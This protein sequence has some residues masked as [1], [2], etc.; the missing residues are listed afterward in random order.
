MTRPLNAA[1]YP[2]DHPNNHAHNAIVFVHGY[3]A[4][5]ADLLSLA[6]MIKHA[7][8]HTAFYAPNAPEA[9]PELANGWQ[10]F[11]VPWLDGSSE[12]TMIQGLYRSQTD[13]DAY[14]N[15]LLAKHNFTAKQ[16][17]LFGFSQGAMLALH[18][19]LR[20]YDAIAGVVAIAGGVLVPTRLAQEIQSKPPVL[21]LHGNDDNVVPHS[22][23]EQ[24]YKSMRDLAIDVDIHIEQGAGHTI[25]E[26]GLHKAIHFVQQCLATNRS[27]QSL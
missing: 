19:A 22:M 23:S 14:L 15:A 7:L 13:L 8:P 10:W 16:I 1:H 17:I 9:I 27:T 11:S 26:Q 2:R 21:L 6:P 12:T 5:G 25:T 24:A 4:N 3:G 20:R 18:T